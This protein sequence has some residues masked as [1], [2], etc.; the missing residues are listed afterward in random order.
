M[1]PIESLEN[2]N[3]LS[4]KYKS[5]A[6]ENGFIELNRARVEFDGRQIKNIASLIDGEEGT[7]PEYNLGKGLRYE[8]KSGNYASMKIHIDDLQTFINRVK[9]HY[10]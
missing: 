5:F 6:D 8:G 10:K 3:V 7:S 2:K 4:D 9:E 1:K